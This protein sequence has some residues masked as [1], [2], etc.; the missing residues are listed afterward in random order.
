MDK[1]VYKIQPFGFGWMPST[2]SLNYIYGR[3]GTKYT[4]KFEV[5]INLKGNIK[6]VYAKFTVNGKEVTG[7]YDS[8][9]NY[10]GKVRL[11]HVPMEG[12]YSGWE[13]WSAETPQEIDADGVSF[14]IISD[15]SQPY[16]V[17]SAFVRKCNYISHKLG[18]ADA[19][20]D[21]IL[22]SGLSGVTIKEH[23][24]V[25]V[26]TQD[27][28]TY[29][30]I[31]F[32]NSYVKSISSGGVEVYRPMSGVS[33]IA[34]F[35]SNY[36]DTR[37][38]VE[39]S[40]LQSMIV[41]WQRRL[42]IRYTNGQASVSVHKY[43]LL[44]NYLGAL[45]LQEIHDN[46][47]DV[48]DT[49]GEE[50]IDGELQK[51]LQVSLVKNEASHNFNIFLSKIP[52]V[53]NEEN[54]FSKFGCNLRLDRKDTSQDFEAMTLTNERFSVIFNAFDPVSYREGIDKPLTIT[55]VQL[56]D[57][58]SDNPKVMYELEYLP[59]VYSELRNHVSFNILFY[60]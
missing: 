8:N 27:S 28:N 22:T 31:Q 38:K 24:S 53:L 2:S 50:T 39:D 18:L 25:I 32:N 51:K 37:K 6:S 45:E 14:E 12:G 19:L 43:G 42:Y 52:L 40:R 57:N 47:S 46:T 5:A 11:N 1:D 33:R 44:P 54:Q 23:S 4:A 16:Y 48:V 29:Y 21:V 30:P 49:L 58:S 60:V 20:N 13:T 34:E 59:I 35:I 17:A 36:K 3:G 55:N 15:R 56:I 9:G 26:K 41:P 10:L 7:N